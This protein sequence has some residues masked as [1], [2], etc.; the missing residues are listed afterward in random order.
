MFGLFKKEATPAVSSATAATQPVPIPPAPL[1][2]GKET[3]TRD[4]KTGMGIYHRPLTPEQ[5][6][7]TM[8]AVKINMDAGQN[9]FHLTRQARHAARMADESEK[10]MVETEKKL[11]QI[12]DKIRDEQKLGRMWGLNPHLMVMERQDPPA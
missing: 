1:E 12:V 4:P 7:T 2:T 6:S 9:F 5:F 10:Q 3:F 8:A 11:G